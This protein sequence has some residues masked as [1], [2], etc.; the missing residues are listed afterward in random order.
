MEQQWIALGIAIVTGSSTLIGVAITNYF[1]I[2]AIEKRHKFEAEENEKKT[3][4]ELRKEVYLGL[5][6]DIYLLNT[7]IF[8]CINDRQ[9]RSENNLI[10]RL[11]T[12]IRKLQLISSNEISYEADKLNSLFTKVMFDLN[13]GLKEI[14]MLEYEND[15]LDKFTQRYQKEFDSFSSLSNEVKITELDLSLKINKLEIFHKEMVN[16][17]IKIEKMNEDFLENMNKI[18]EY[19]KKL[20]MEMIDSLKPLRPIL[21]NLM[22]LMRLDLGV[23]D[24]YKFDLHEYDLE[25]NQFKEY[26]KD[27]IN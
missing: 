10:N 25:H 4:L 23:I 12:Q 24:Q 13:F 8:K 11:N 9:S 16:T 21:I 2:K 26:L 18:D 5:A 14:I 15:N 19:K 6:E 17:Q 20:M 3:K 1:N 22:N 7:F 27:K